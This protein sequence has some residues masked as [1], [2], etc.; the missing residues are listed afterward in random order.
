M[1]NFLQ[2]DKYQQKILRAMHRN[3][4]KVESFMLRDIDDYCEISILRRPCVCLESSSQLF[5]RSCR[6]W[7]NHFWMGRLPTP[8][9]SITTPQTSFLTFSSSPSLWRRYLAGVNRWKTKS[10]PFNNTLVFI[11]TGPLFPLL[12]VHPWSH[13]PVP[14]LTGGNCILAEH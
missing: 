13:F 4:S 7:Q 12:C 1:R 5:C 9:L 6:R 10:S 3:L 2:P 11:A 8:F 14:P